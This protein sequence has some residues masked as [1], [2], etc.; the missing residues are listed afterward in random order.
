MFNIDKKVKS[1]IK[2]YEI[3]ENKDKYY[4]NLRSNEK[5]LNLQYCIFDKFLINIK[6]KIETLIDFNYDQFKTLSIIHKNYWNSID[7]KLVNY[8]KLSQSKIKFDQIKKTYDAIKKEKDKSKILNHYANLE[9]YFKDINFSDFEMENIIK[10]LKKFDEL[11]KF[12]ESGLKENFFNKVGTEFNEIENIIRDIK[13]NKLL[14]IQKLC[15]EKLK[16]I[17]EINED[18]YNELVNFKKG[19]KISKSE[20]FLND[21]LSNLNISNE[22]IFQSD[23][24]YEKNS[25]VSVANESYFDNGKVNQLLSNQ[26]LIFDTKVHKSFSSNEI[27][28]FGNLASFYERH[29]TNSNLPTHLTNSQNSIKFE[30]KFETPNKIKNIN[31]SFQLCIYEIED[32]HA[33]NENLN[34]SSIK[35][36]NI[37][38]IIPLE[39]PVEN[40]EF[41]NNLLGDLPK[42]TIEEPTKNNNERTKN[43]IEPTK[44]YMEPTQNNNEPSN[45]DIEPIKNEMEPSKSK[46]VKEPNNIDL[47]EIV[48]SASSKSAE[49][50]MKLFNSLN[51]TQKSNLVLMSFGCN[52]KSVFIYNL[53]L[54]EVKEE[55]IEFKFPSFHSFI[56]YKETIYLTGGKDMNTNKSINSLSKILRI[57]S[58]NFSKINLEPMHSSR[59]NHNSFIHDGQLYVIS[60]S[61]NSTVESYNIIT[62]NWIYLPSLNTSRERCCSMISNGDIYVFLGFHRETN[63]FPCTFERLQTGGDKWVIINPKCSQSYLKK[64]SLSLITLSNHNEKVY[65]C[66]GINQ[67]KNESTDCFVYDFKKNSL[68]LCKFGFSTNSSFV[69]NNFQSLLDDNIYVNMSETFKVFQ[70]DSINEIMS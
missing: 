4:E 69:H 21:D 46:S 5:H 3:A 10:N 25:V 29:C 13:E 37:P 60:G 24:N 18:D 44:N 6:E 33:V 15:I 12:Y 68:N 49:E 66:G 58:N 26:S 56:N 30:N 59:F 27:N 38:H 40:S 23:Q 65:L 64:H 39:K 55:E 35:E 34:F 2:F 50:K 67:Y 63:Q 31:K 20:S 16:E 19:R 47:R 48:Y 9:V 51:H 70:F 61:R 45:N 1:F 57:S 62:N 52:C 32:T 17:L 42:S 8:E 7:E 41:R 28:K 11:S 43:E 36:T 22:K 54:N 53:L 14:K